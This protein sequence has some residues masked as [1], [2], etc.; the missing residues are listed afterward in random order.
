MDH[1]ESNRPLVPPSQVRR[2]LDPQGARPFI[3]G[4]H[5][6]GHGLLRAD[7]PPSR[8]DRQHGPAER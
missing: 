7:G 1:P 5:G 4:V 8:M 6:L 3:N 2:E